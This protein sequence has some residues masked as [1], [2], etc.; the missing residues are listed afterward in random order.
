MQ[1]KARA[2]VHALPRQWGAEWVSVAMTVL[3]FALFT[4]FWGFLLEEIARGS[5][6][7]RT[8]ASVPV[9]VGLIGFLQAR[10]IGIGDSGAERWGLALTATGCLFLLVLLLLPTPR[11]PGWT[12]KWD[13][14]TPVHVTR[15]EP[16]L[17]NLLPLAVMAALLMGMAGAVIS[18]IA[19]RIRFR[20]RPALAACAAWGGLL[21]ATWLFTAPFG[22][23][24][25]GAFAMD[26]A[27]GGV[28]GLA[29][30]RTLTPTPA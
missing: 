2:L 24:G 6:G 14:G 27:W 13:M 25:W 1:A 3:C 26:L 23:S 30:A 22:L 29:F 28:A 16:V 12:P 8:M 11:E 7:F 15:V 5:T 18:L 19:L 9:S 10:L 17:R 20:L 21:M 4:P